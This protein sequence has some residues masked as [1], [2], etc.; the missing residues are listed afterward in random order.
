MS[1]VLNVNRKVN[2]EIYYSPNDLLSRNCLINFVLGERGNGK[3]F[4]FKDYAIRDF[5]RKGNQFI[6]LRRYDTE[7]DDIDLFFKD[8]NYKYP[9]HEFKASGGKFYCDDE[10]MGFYFPLS[11]ALT[12]KS[13]P[14]PDVSKII[15]DEFIIDKGNYHYLPH[16][17]E[18]FFDVVETIGRL[19]DVR[20]FLIA[21]SI[22]EVNPFFAYFNIKIEGRFTKVGE[23]ILVEKTYSPYYREVKKQTRFGKIISKTNYGKYAIDNEFVK[24]NHNFIK[25]K[26]ENARNMFNINING[27]YVGIWIDYQKGEM[28]CS[29]KYNPDMIN[30]SAYAENMQPNYLMFNSQSNNI[31]MLKQ[32]LQYGYLYYDSFKVK[33]TM[34]EVVKLLNI[35]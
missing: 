29:F 4:G 30:I 17:P 31:K 32:A 3:T 26:S 10:I 27:T 23:D 28:Y 5:L 1:E 13:I 12:K 33:A 15:Y 7:F 19:R 22:T 24:D 20:C 25:K 18:V 34:Q 16:E 2:S 21:N 9:T 6:W 8:I 11:K 14:Y 35:H